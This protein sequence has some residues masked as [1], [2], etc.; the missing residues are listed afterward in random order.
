M[1][2]KATLFIADLHLGPEQPQV[3]RLFETFLAGPARQAEALYILG[4]LF[5][6]WLGD[7]LLLPFCEPL[8]QGLRGLTRSGV[9]VYLMHG[10]RDFLLG[11]GFCELTG[12]TLLEEPANIELYGTPTL[13]MHG[14]MLCSD[15][16]AYLAMRQQLRDPDWIKVFLAKPPAERIAFA[17]SLRERSQQENTMK[18]EQIMDV[19]QETVC[20]TLRTHGLHQ[21]IHGH[22]HRPAQHTFELDGQP[23]RRHVLPD[24][25]S[26]PGVLRC[27]AQGCQ[28][29]PLGEI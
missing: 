9:P 25:Q 24:W 23:A 28:L 15:D 22:T 11:E 4:D 21:L 18:S 20:A 29:L 27:D 6:A 16:H 17:R 19:N 14:D 10:N 13:L 3:N 1:T 5:E 8:L 26:A 7:D 2:N 12:C